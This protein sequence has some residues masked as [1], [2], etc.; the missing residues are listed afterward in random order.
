MSDAELDALEAAMVRREA[1]EEPRDGDEA[2]SRR[3]WELYEEALSEL[4]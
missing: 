2:I 1:G 3:A 4:A